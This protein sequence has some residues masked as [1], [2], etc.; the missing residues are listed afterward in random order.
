ML[1][2]K[3]LLLLTFA[4][5]TPVIA[6]KLFGSTLGYPLDGGMK[7]FDGQP[8][9]GRS[10]TVRGVVLSVLI[11]A[12]AAPLLGF[13]W[14]TG[15]AVAALSMFGD[16]I[17]SFLKRRLRLP[18]SSMALGLDQIPEALLPL[19]ALRSRLGLGGLDIAVVVTVFFIGE[20]L[21]SRVLFKLNIRDRPY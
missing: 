10:K 18:S 2:L 13:T 15:A 1:E 7:F 19:L 17:S 5:G 9:L 11:T 14:T 16:L 8:L 20:L 4:N 6:R 12:L 21:L 3:L